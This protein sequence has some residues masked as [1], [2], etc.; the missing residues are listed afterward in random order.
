[1]VFQHIGYGL[2]AAKNYASGH[3]SGLGHALRGKTLTNTVVSTGAVYGGIKLVGLVAS[4]VTQSPEGQELADIVAPLAVGVMGKNALERNHASSGY[5]G[6]GE[7]LLSLGVSTDF[8]YQISQVSPGTILTPAQQAYDF[9][10]A[11][12]FAKINVP[13]ILD[14]TIIGSGLWGL[15]KLRNSKKARNSKK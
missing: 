10:H 6:L 1:M 4:S 9:L 3:L 11:H 13:Q 12:T 7:L 15:T 14:G 2:S 5:K 8:F